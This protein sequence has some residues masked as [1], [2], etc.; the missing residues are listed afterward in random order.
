M[1]MLSFTNA[2]NT[3]AASHNNHTA[4]NHTPTQSCATECSSDRG[5]CYLPLTLSADID[6][7]TDTSETWTA[8]DA[9]NLDLP[10]RL[11]QNRPFVSNSLDASRLFKLARRQRFDGAINGT[12]ASQLDRQQ[13][14]LVVRWTREGAAS[15]SA[16]AYGYIGGSPPFP[17]DSDPSTILLHPDDA[18]TASPGGLVYVGEQD[19]KIIASPEKAGNYTAWILVYD[20]AGERLAKSSLHNLKHAELWSQAVVAVWNFEVGGKLPFAVQG[21]NRVADAEYSDG[22]G[23]ITTTGTTMA[24]NDC[25]VGS[26]Y[27]IAPIDLD[28]LT[29]KN[30]RKGLEADELIYSFVLEG[31]P[32]GF[33]VDT[34][35]GE[36]I[37]VPTMPTARAVT[38]KLFVV[39]GSGDKAL[40]QTI[41]IA[42]GKR[43]TFVLSA[44]PSR[45]RAGKEY[46]DPATASRQYFVDE[47]Y[48]IAPLQ[49]NSGTTLPSS[50]TVD[51]IKFTLV[52]APETWFI[53]ADSGIITGKFNAT[54]NYNFS[55]VAVDAGG[56]K[57]TVEEY[58]FVV[59]ERG[60]F[61]VLNYAYSQMPSGTSD[62]NQSDYTD[63]STTTTYAVGETYRFP[64]I[65]RNLLETENPNDTSDLTFAV[66][67][68]PPGLLINPADGYIQATPTT[69]GDFTVTLNAENSRNEKA[70]IAIMTMVIKYNDGDMPINGPNRA[71]CANG[72]PVDG[73][74]FDRSFT[75]NCDGTQ[76]E[77][78]NCELDKPGSAG[79]SAQDAGGGDNVGA[80]VG[81]MVAGMIVLAA[82]GIMIYKRR[83]YKLS[84]RAHNF[85]VHLHELLE[86]GEIDAP[87]SDGGDGGQR[88]PREIKRDHITMTA[89]VG[90]GAFGE[91]WKA[92][93]DESK[94]GGVPGYMCAVKTSKEAKG[95]GA[96]ELLREALVMAQLTGHPNVVSLIGVV[97]SGVPLLLLLSLCENGSLQSCLKEGTCPGQA[98]LPGTAPS[99][100]SVLKMALE[101]ARGMKHL[102][103][104]KFVHRDLAARNVLLDSEFVCKVADFGLSRGVAASNT[105]D[106]NAKE[107]YTSRNGTFPVRWTSPEAI[108]TMKFSTATDI[109]SYAVVLLEI[110]TGGRRPYDG[111][112]NEE[113]VQ[114]VMAGYRAP[115][116]EPGC[117]VELYA[118]MLDCWN[119]VA[120][121][122]PS[123]TEL[124]SALEQLQQHAGGNNVGGDGAGGSASAAAAA[125]QN[126]NEYLMPG[127]GISGGSDA[128]GEQPPVADNEYLQPGVGLVIKGSQPNTNSVEGNAAEYSLAS[129]EAPS[130]PVRVGSASAATAAPALA[131]YSLASAAPAQTGSQ[132]HASVA[133]GADAPPPAT[134]P[135]ATK[136]LEE[137]NDDLGE[138]A[139]P[140][141]GG[142]V[143]GA[144]FGLSA[145]SSPLPAVEKSAVATAAKPT[146]K[147]RPKS[148]AY[149]GS[150]AAA[151]AATGSAGAAA[152]QT[153]AAP[154]ATVRRKAK[155]TNPFVKL[156]EEQ[157]KKKKKGEAFKG[158]TINADVGTISI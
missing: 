22:T 62:L 157:A 79:S 29:T 3:S 28:T 142:A 101:I 109:W 38:A 60:T 18:D 155:D 52:G 116:P 88:V 73:V 53:S 138:Y 36:I 111:M 148:A 1:E 24:L 146:P 154:K 21:Y 41:S 15:P 87:A 84:M 147:P 78:L 93:L 144:D 119:D 72:K 4:T 8:A 100:A 54:G 131:E 69:P 5:L 130:V 64:P 114:K 12:T 10:A 13:L 58:T 9:A 30:A 133:A 74:P 110:V 7:D 135:A 23:F 123:F 124:V 34:S 107:Y 127:V 150:P 117:S 102:V 46:T 80:V 42:V 85:E 90:A 51:D 122:R 44:G 68:A 27:K 140:S 112:R 65:D 75:C 121:K 49:V 153:N 17:I 37:G 76:F 16:D 19:G 45:L 47:N 137:C 104:G 89:V 83:V 105:D 97:T 63:P 134:T 118:V 20:P 126:P 2:S 32:R 81:A 95:D 115:R 143:I 70:K 92:V 39:D 25:V 136:P 125:G 132:W 141:A 31:A 77:G 156:I 6:A 43:P 67:G 55:I 59:A 50:G 82:A 33:F 40:L 113:V 71:G 108:E 56:Q 94:A 129:Q 120:G 66:Q 98:N 35:N 151:A 139:A 57:D 86:T 106:E 14:Q 61:R 91:V 152:A 149:G 128:S 158:V 26:T 11:E 96:D 103:D 48:L 99:N 145:Y